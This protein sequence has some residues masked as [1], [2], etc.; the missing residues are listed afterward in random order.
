VQNVINSTG[1]RNNSGITD[2][3]GLVNSQKV[4]LDW[5]FRMKGKMWWF[6]HEK[7]RIR[8]AP[9]VGVQVNF[10]KMSHIDPQHGV[11]CQEFVSKIKEFGGYCLLGFKWIRRKW[12]WIKPQ[13]W[14]QNVKNA[15][16]KWSNSVSL[17]VGA[18]VNSQK[19]SIDLGQYGMQKCDEFYWIL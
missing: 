11:K 8:G 19:M 15:I 16:R 1:K 17:T 10:Q 12:G 7:E 13:Y 4:S 5:A 6:P 2:R 3:W 9:T 14:K 18:H